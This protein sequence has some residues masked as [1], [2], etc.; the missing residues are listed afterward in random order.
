M[1]RFRDVPSAL[2]I[3]VLPMGIV[4][5]ATVWAMVDQAIQQIHG[6]GLT[7]TVGP[8][9][10][11]VEGPLDQLLDLAATVHRTVLV[12]GAPTVATYMKL[13]SG[14]G[15]GTSKEKIEKYRAQGH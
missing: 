10:T 6:T 5:R 7:Y 1:N 12:A 4:D 3:Q 14:E 8:F 2:A 15:I 13:W 11:V 9:E